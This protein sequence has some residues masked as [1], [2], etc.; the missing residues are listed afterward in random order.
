MYAARN[1]NLWKTV[2]TLRQLLPVRDALGNCWMDLG[3]ALGL[4]Q[5]ALRNIKADH[6]SNKEKAYAVLWTWMEKEGDQATIGRL[7]VALIG[8]R[9][10]DIVHKLLGM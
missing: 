3:I 2:V 7:A 9:K 8:L 10:Y 6:D 4:K 5:E 1:S